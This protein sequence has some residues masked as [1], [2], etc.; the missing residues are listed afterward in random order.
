MTRTRGRSGGR[1]LQTAGIAVLAGGCVFGGRPEVEPEPAEVFLYEVEYYVSCSISDE[2]RVTY[3][4]QEGL[5]RSQEI[6]GEW[7]YAFGVNPGLRLWLRASAGGCPPRPVRAEIWLDGVVVAQ[8][9]ERPT[10]RS[11]CDWI[12]SETAFIV[13]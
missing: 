7:D 5:L 2:C 8:S 3:I 10:H 4:D 9:L 11:R 12:L 6:V 1:T 13:P